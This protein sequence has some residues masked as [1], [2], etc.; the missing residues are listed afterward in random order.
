MSDLWLG[1]R[2]L[3][4]ESRD[5]T[6]LNLQ[7]T[8]G[9]PEAELLKGL[10]LVRRISTSLC[11][12]ITGDTR[13]S[14]EQIPAGKTGSGH[15]HLPESQRQAQESICATHP[16]PVIA[17][18][19]RGMFHPVNRRRLWLTSRESLLRFKASERSSK[20]DGSGSER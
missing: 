16:R 5:A 13:G 8:G 17:S 20:A 7:C 1:A 19:L 2:P 18:L 14:P 11:R 3:F 4:R 10:G 6:R 15:A 12:G 9:C